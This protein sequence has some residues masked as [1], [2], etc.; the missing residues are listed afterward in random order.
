VV[1]T[2]G[3]YGIMYIL[4]RQTQS[5]LVAVRQEVNNLVKSEKASQ[6]QGNVIYEWNQKSTQVDKLNSERP[7]FSKY[8]DELKIVT[9]PGVVL[10]DV[11][12]SEKPF[13]AALTGITVSPS[14]LAQFGRNLQESIYFKNCLVA[15]SQKRQKDNAYDFTITVTPV[16]KGGSK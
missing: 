13:S 4:Q 1:I 10:T 7:M 16:Q 8:L 5:Q 14:Q 11:L 9:P 2:I 3:T 12:I 15:G 6:V